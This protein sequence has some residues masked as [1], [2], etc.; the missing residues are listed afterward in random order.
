[1]MNFVFGMQINIEVFYKLI[2]SF[3][4]YVIRH[5]QGTQNKFVYL[6]ISP[7]KHVDEVN[8]WHANKHESLLQIDAILLMG[9]V[10]YSQSSS[11]SKFVMFLE[12]LKDEVR[13]ELDFLHADK[14]Q[15][16]HLISALWSSKFPTR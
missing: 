5:A 6:A 12:Y 8:S 2:L 11:N 15:F 7:E 14:H 13:D 4:L 9:M 16:Q 1:M 3:W 10:K